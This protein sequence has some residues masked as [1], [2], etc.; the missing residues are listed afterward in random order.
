VLRAGHRV[1][2]VPITYRARAREE[3]KKLT[4]VDALRVI[5]VLVR[6]R[7]GR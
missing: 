3:G 7:F 4:G 1:F 5:A 6:R 2:E